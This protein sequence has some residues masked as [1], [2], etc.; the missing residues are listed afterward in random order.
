MTDDPKHNSVGGVAAD[1]LRSYVTRLENLNGE[2]DALAED[3]AEVYSEAKS[4]GFCKKTL[5]KVIARRRGGRED[6][7]EEDALLELYEAAIA[8][9]DEQR[10]ALA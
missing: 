7:A 1:Q 9:S 4:A 6:T 2:T 5:R 10:D 3:K 8:T